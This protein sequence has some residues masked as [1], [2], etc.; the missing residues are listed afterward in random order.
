MNVVILILQI[1]E[2]HV[3]IKSKINNFKSLEKKVCIKIFYEN[4]FWYG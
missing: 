2:K 3:D 1:K 4:Y